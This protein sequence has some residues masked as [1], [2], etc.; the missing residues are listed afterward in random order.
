MFKSGRLHTGILHH[1]S[2]CY[3]DAWDFS[4]YY[5]PHCIQ[6]VKSKHS[7]DK[8][9]HH[10]SLDTWTSLT[11]RSIK[12]NKKVINSNL[13]D[14]VRLGMLYRKTLSDGF[15]DKKEFIKNKSWETHTNKLIKTCLWLYLYPAEAQEWRY[16][17]L[18]SEQWGSDKVRMESR[19]DTDNGL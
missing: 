12:A 19:W 15:G 4:K 10:S 2:N 13:V 3:C 5:W 6:Q 17:M 14:G 9:H 1:F 8:P 18:F 11:L 7:L 16:N